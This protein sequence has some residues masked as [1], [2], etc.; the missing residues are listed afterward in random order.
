MKIF[1]R[2]PALWLAALQAV[3]TVFVGF[4]LDGLNAEQA[5]LW[6]ALVNVGIGVVMA[7][8]VRPI[9][10]VVFT[11]AFSTVAT[12]GAA[13]GLDM[14]QEMVASINLAIVA[15]VTLLARGQVSPT[16]DAP[17]TG[18][19]GSKVTTGGLPPTAR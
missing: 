2:E 6:V 12:L 3:L 18:V 7:W 14:S 8:S 17:Q 15:V 4:G 13:Y 19:L 9:S 5:S 10:P 1:G 11:T 16:P